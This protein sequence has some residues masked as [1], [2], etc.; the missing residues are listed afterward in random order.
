MNDSD[1]LMSQ[2]LTDKEVKEYSARSRLP[3]RQKQH[4]EWRIQGPFPWGLWCVVAQFPGKSLAIWM[5]IHHRSKLS[6]QLWITLPHE[7]LIE[8]GISQ[9]A[10]DRALRLL[11]RHGLI[12][13]D[14]RRGHPTRIALV[15]VAPGDEVE[16]VATEGGAG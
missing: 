16:M 8:A 5:L 9:D 3:V 6:R 1:N 11:E 14:R 12:C 15:Q 13:V 10:K 2:A 4:R 7:L